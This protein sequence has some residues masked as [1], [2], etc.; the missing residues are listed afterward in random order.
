MNT[1]RRDYIPAFKKWLIIFGSLLDPL[2]ISA[3]YSFI[4][5][6]SAKDNPPPATAGTAQMHHVPPFR[7][8]G[9]VCIYCIDRISRLG[10]QHMVKHLSTRQAAKKK[11]SKKGRRIFGLHPE[12]KKVDRKYRNHFAA[13]NCY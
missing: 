2:H 4:H 1:V 13:Q 6:L 11:I 9:G 3:T 5:A 7:T 8:L 10:L 12:A